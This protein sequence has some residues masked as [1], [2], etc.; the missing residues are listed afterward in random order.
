MASKPS[1]SSSSAAATTD[2]LFC[3]WG[4]TSYNNL[5]QDY[6]IRA[7]WNPILPSKTDTAFPLKA[8]KITLFSDFF[9]FCN[10]RL[11]VTKFLKLVLDFYR[12]HISQLHPLGL[13]KLRQFEFACIALGH[14]PELV[15]F[16]AF[17]VLVWKS[18]FFTFDR[19]DTDV[20]C[21]RDIP[22]SSRDKDWKKKFFYIDA[23]VIPGEMH[24]R[25][26]GPKDKVK[27][28]GPSEDAYVSN[29]L[30]TKMCGR[31]FKCTVIPEGALV[32]AGMSLLWRDIRRYPREWSMFDFVNPPRHLALKPADRV[33]DE[34]ELDVL[35]MHLEQ[36]IL[37]A[38]PAD[39]TSYI[40][41]LPAA[42][43]TSVPALEKKTARIKL[44]GK[45]QT[46]TNVAVASI[47]E[48]A[49]L[50]RGI[51]LSASM[52]S[53]GRALKKRKTFVVPTL[54][55]FEAVQAAHA[56]PIST[57][58]GVQTGVATSTPVATVALSVPDAS[59]GVSAEPKTQASAT[60]AISCA[61][62]LP[63][64]TL[65]VVV[66]VDPIVAPRTCGVGTSLFDS[67]ISIFSVA[68][69]E[70]TA[71][72]VAQEVT[73]LGGAAASEAG[74]SSSGI[75]DD[76]VRLIDD[77][78]LPTVR[79]DPNAQ[80][81]RYQPQWKIAE[82]SRLIFPPVI[83]HWV[84]R[85][86]PPAEAAYVEGLNNEDLMNSSISD[87]V[88]LPRRLMEIR[89]RWMHD[90]TQL[91]Q[92]RATI[93]ELTDDKHRLESQLQ[94]A[95]LKEARYLSEKNKAEEDLKRVTAHLAEERIM[96]ARDVAEKDRVLAQAKNI[97]EELERKAIAE[98]QKVRLEL[99]TQLEKFRVDTDF[100]SQ[101]QERYQGL[102]A[103][104]E[105]SHTKIWLLQAELEEREGKVKELQD[106]CD[107]KEVE[108]ALAQSNAEVDD[109]TSQLAAVRGDRNWLITNGLVGA[110]E[111]LRES[112]PFTNLIDRLSAAAYQSG[113]HDGVYKGYMECH[114]LDKIP[115][116]FHAVKSKLQ[117]DMSNALEAVYTEPLPC[118][119]DLMD[120]VNEDGIESLRLMLDPTEESEEE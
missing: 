36:F 83:Q 66:T 17:F 114:Q 108:N 4:V 24:W 63:T 21:L 56:L 119:G 62:P 2:V 18:P 65:S 15:V 113:H 118:Y 69:K 50:G 77:L 80:D 101:V 91:H 23:S 8:G 64:P 29:V 14:I 46:T 58:T 52:T 10:F 72:S 55:A 100:V 99:S 26:K 35:G 96:W 97:Q 9:K 5:V 12:I 84:E 54:S 71:V 81:K 3:K 44:T 30:Y 86:Y 42:S 120:K 92:A 116:D 53:P 70:V 89:R 112:S 31:P 59:I 90:N 110:F 19:R 25:E 7:E 94:T 109:L 27:D 98:A 11:P 57:S 61:M 85:A 88:S 68:E 51:S 67:P 87:S 78:F 47:E 48:A 111:Y 6:G 37:P 40:S 106:H 74:G 45:K 105:A 82:S 22:T 39:P 102:T 104:V 93:Q 79:W 43:T 34:G 103:E 76:G 1:E 41:P 28:E 38:V 32:M 73:S 20:S 60:A 117:S 16:R 107:L 49:S 33:L 95:G 13:V 115:P 75:A